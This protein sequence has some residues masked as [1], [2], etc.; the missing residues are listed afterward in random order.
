MLLYI[1]AGTLPKTCILEKM[2]PQLQS[3]ISD[4]AFWLGRVSNDPALREKLIDELPPSVQRAY[5]YEDLCDKVFP[6]AA[7]ARIDPDSDSDFLASRAILAV[8]NADL[9]SLNAK[10]IQRLPGE[11]KTL[12]SAEST[13]ADDVNGYEA[14][15]REFLQE[16]DLPDFPPSTLELKV[17]APVM[18]LRDL[19]PSDGFCN[20]T[21]LVIKKLPGRFVMLV[22]ILSGKFKGND[23]LL[24][25]ISFHSQQGRLP[26]TLTRHQFPV[27]LCFA[28]DIN[29]SPGQS[30]ET[31]GVDL[32]SALSNRQLLSQVT[33]VQ[34]LVVRVSENSKPN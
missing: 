32:Y 15:P 4:F 22:E 21:R 9:S 14:F 2:G 34:Q 13:D 31:V 20:G 7:M 30:L 27:R 33:D 29:K 8:R 5:S 19:N 6:A 11:L 23:C 1:A 3:V 26:F 12:Y 17:G 10:L 24:P 28:M 16:I 18:L 25:R